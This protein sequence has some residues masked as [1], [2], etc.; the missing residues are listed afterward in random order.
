LR[1]ELPTISVGL[2]KYVLAVGMDKVGII[3]LGVFMRTVFRA[4]GSKCL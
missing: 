1:R 2:F 3:F 4:E